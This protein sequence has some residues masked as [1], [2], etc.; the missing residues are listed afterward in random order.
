MTKN[1]DS[2][3]KAEVVAKIEGVTGKADVID[4]R[5]FRNATDATIDLHAE[6]SSH[7]ANRRKGC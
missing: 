4:R 1:T 5:S 7:V 6:I 3:L 2:D